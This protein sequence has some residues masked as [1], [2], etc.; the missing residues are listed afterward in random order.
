VQGEKDPFGI[1]ESDLGRRRSV[2][3]VPGTHTLSNQGA[4][5][6]EV[7]IWLTALLAGVVR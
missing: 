5:R 1:P 7:A 6:D 2:V 3:V 4:V